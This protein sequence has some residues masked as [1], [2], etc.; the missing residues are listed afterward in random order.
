[1]TVRLFVAML[2]VGTIGT[3]LPGNSRAHC[4]PDHRHYRGMVYYFTCPRSLPHAFCICGS[5]WMNMDSCV[6]RDWTSYRLLPLPG[7]PCD[8]DDV[9][10]EA[11]EK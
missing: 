2:I 11:E 7:N 6:R 8:P 3:S 10:A 1:M 5:P 4:G 9:A